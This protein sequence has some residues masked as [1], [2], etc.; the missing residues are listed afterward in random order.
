MNDTARCIEDLP[1]VERSGPTIAH[2]HCW[3]VRESFP[4]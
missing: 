3:G 4:R 1:A 2:A